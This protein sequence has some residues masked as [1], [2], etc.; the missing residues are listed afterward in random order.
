MALS[1]GLAGV[2]ISLIPFAGYALAQISCGRRAAAT[3]AITFFAMPSYFVILPAHNVIRLSDY[4]CSGEVYFYPKIRD[5]GK[6]GAFSEVV[7]A[8]EDCFRLERG[9]GID[10]PPVTQEQA[11]IAASFAAL[12][13]KHAVALRKSCRE[14]DVQFHERQ[15]DILLASVGLRKV[16]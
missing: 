5:A 4:Q 7:G 1:L 15:A 14:K 13:I 11:N 2:V 9:F 8:Y 3:A 10:K 16:K 6:R 12:L